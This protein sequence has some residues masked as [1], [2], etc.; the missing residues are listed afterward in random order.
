[1]RIHA[2]EKKERALG[3]PLFLKAQRSNSPKSALVKKPYGP[4]QHGQKRKRGRPSEYGKQLK[5]KQ[6]IQ[7]S[8]GLTDKQM[9]AIFKQPKEKIVGILRERLDYVVFLSGFVESP[10][11]ARQ[12]VSHGHITINGKKMTIPSY[13]VTVGDIVSIRNE[14]RASKL[15]EEMSERLKKSTAPSWLKVDAQNLKAECINPSASEDVQ[16]PFDLSLVGE[17]YSR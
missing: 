16:F 17:F 2:K 1:M 8:F 13:H 14:S 10:R 11:I 6:K 15:F 3:T 7:I 4:G 9:R 12:I 5:E